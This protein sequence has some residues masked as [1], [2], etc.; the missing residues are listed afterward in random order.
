MIAGDGAKKG[1][2]PGE[3][4]DSQVW[5]IPEEELFEGGWELEEI[6]GVEQILDGGEDQKRIFSTVLDLTEDEVRVLRRGAGQWP[7]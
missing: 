4:E 1:P 7:I 3:D 5:S 2:A 6:D